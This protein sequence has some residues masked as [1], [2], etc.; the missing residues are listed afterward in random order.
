MYHSYHAYTTNIA[1]MLTYNIF[2][3]TLFIS[4]ISILELCLIIAMKH[5]VATYDGEPFNFQMVFNGKFN[6]IVFWTVV[7]VKLYGVYYPNG[8]TITHVPQ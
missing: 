2:I 5:L 8:D 7:D 6:N 4:G 3:Y 1:H